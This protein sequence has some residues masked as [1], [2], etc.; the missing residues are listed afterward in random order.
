MTVVAA[1]KG[2]VPRIIA[3]IG[4]VA[5]TQS[6]TVRPR[7]DGE[8]TEIDFAEGDIVKADDVLAKLD[9]RALQATLDGAT[10]KKAQDQAL[11]AAAQSD[12]ERYAALADKKVVS[13]QDFE[14]KKATA[15]QLEAT[16]VADNA[17]IASA[18]TE[19][20]YATIRAPIGG[21]TG[22]KSV[23][24][25]SVVS[26]NSQDGLVTISQLDPISVVFVAPGDRFGEIQ[27]AMKDGVADVEAI[28]TDGSRVLARG[29][30]DLMDNIVNASN[31]SIRLRA[32]FD[33][34]SGALWPGLPVATRLTVAK[35]NGIVVPDKALARGSDG[36]SAYVIDGSQK[37]ARHA[38]S[39][40]VTTDGM[41]IVTKGLSD[42]D[43][44][45]FD[46]LGQIAD[47]STVH[48]LGPGNTSAPADQAVAA[49]GSAE[50]H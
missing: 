4:V 8:V 20:S 11:L 34:K 12:L 37:A 29:K 44:I 13:S 19:L 25:G 16:V 2:V 32:T 23:S 49:N 41:A 45:V 7:I 36:L 21:R 50:G 43:S 42:N 6:V 47:G 10:A 26:A 46:G 17:A 1:R 39:V 24:I 18:H 28:A 5:A 31:G 27:Q 3:G 48:V 14:S 40:S 35:V 9:P 22:F 33:N 30:L 15:A 38:V